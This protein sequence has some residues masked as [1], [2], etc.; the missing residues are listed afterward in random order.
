MSIKAA[1]VFVKL[2][3][4]ENLLA[5][6]YC[7]LFGFIQLF[8]FLKYIYPHQIILIS[9]ERVEHDPVV[10]RIHGF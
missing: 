4:C 9:I 10:I 2:T 8:L 7:F 6:S 3:F 5:G 1:K